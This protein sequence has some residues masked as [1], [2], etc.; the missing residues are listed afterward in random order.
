[1]AALQVLQPLKEQKKK[2]G[3]KEILRQVRPGYSPLRYF[4]QKARLEAWKWEPW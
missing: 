1:M 3:P 2:G 4:S